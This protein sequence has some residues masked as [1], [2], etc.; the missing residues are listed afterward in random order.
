MQVAASGAESTPASVPPLL[1]P[2][3][4]DPPLLDPP[5]LKP[6]LL[7]PPLLD[8]PLLDPPLLFECP[9]LEPPPLD[10]A[11]SVVFSPEQLVTSSAISVAASRSV[12]MASHRLHASDLPPQPTWISPSSR[13]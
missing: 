10:V 2:P 13:F 5:L 8:P 1:D 6:P 7:E 12:S 3:L 11:S 9:L 4:L